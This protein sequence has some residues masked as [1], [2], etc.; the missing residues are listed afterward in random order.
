MNQIPP[1][2][3]LHSDVLLNNTDRIP[4]VASNDGNGGNLMFS[5]QDGSLISLDN[6]IV[7]LRG[8]GLEKYTAKVKRVLGAIMQQPQTPVEGTR[9]IALL[10]ENCTG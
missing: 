2:L 6:G 5:T 1:T 3:S 7:S 4:L 8:V 10:I 9:K